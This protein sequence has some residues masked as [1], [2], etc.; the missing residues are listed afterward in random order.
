MA[1]NR[2]FS[3]CFI[4]KPKI[5]Y[6][7]TAFRAVLCFHKLILY[8]DIFLLFLDAM[9]ASAS[10]DGCIIIWT[11]HRLVATRKFNYF[12]NFMNLTDHTY[13]YSVQHLMVAQT[14]T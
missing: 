3:L 10:M 14:V 8:Y 6:G 9:F 7:I 2:N 5:P 11:T 13:P 12:D 4:I 1:M